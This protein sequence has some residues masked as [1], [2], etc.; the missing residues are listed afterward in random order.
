[1]A[2]I[3]DN[4]LTI[5]VEPNDL[6]YAVPQDR[7]EQAVAQLEALVPASSQDPKLVAKS[8]A[9]REKRVEKANLASLELVSLNTADNCSAEISD[10][11][12]DHHGGCK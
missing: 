8:I 5:F 4:C 12:E 10:T 6:V 1:M 3:W 11:D 7:V 2:T 9:N